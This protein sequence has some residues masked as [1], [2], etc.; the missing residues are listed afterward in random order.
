MPFFAFTDPNTL[1]VTVLGALDYDQRGDAIAPR[2]LPDWTRSQ[3]PQ[4]LDV[5]LRM[6]SGVR[7]AFTTD[8]PTLS[9]RVNTTRMITPRA[10]RRPAVFDL[11]VAGRVTSQSFDCGTRLLLDPDRPDEFEVERGE[12][13]DVSFSL[14]DTRNA[15]VCELWLPHNAF[16]ELYGMTI[17][18]GCELH[19]A[20]PAGPHWVHY[21]SSI[22]HCMEAAQPTGT[23]PAVAALS[24]GARLHSLGFGGQCH[25]DPFVARTIRDLKPDCISIKTG[26]NIVN[27]DSMRERVFVPLLHGF[28]DTIRESCPDT[29]IAVIS[30]I[31]CPSAES[32]PGPTRPDADGRFQT[33]PR[34]PELTDG[35]LTLQRIRSLLAVAVEARRASDPNLCYVDGLELFGQADAGDLPDDL[36]PNPAGYRRMGERFAR[37]AFGD[38]GFFTSLVNGAAT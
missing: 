17:D 20:V 28:L 7:I 8:S 13:Y 34:P 32:Q 24:G 19:P 36:H 25:L 6:P 22:S 26:I 30:P 29:R 11:A 5:M 15:T 16:V 3:V 38:G 2:R 14:P 1:P 21:G 18:A 10:P 27:L 35:A 37:L 23:W 31:F 4:M 33:V 9:L 12:P